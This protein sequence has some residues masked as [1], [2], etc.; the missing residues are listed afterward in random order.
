MTAGVVFMIITITIGVICAI[1]AVAVSLWSINN[2]KVIST[3]N[4]FYTLQD[5]TISSESYETFMQ[6]GAK[7]LKQ[8][9]FKLSNIEV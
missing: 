6:H 1:S 2:D 5:D 8:E 3:C 7:L 4:M 9:D